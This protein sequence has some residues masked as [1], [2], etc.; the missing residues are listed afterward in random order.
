MLKIHS[1]FKSEFDPGIQNPIK[2]N[3]ETL[4]YFSL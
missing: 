1:Y 2:L 4:G 3:V